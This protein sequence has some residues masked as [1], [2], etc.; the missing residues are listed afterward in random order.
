M[1]VVCFPDCFYIDH[2]T[3]QTGKSAD[4]VLEIMSV[5]HETKSIESL[6]AIICDG[7]VANT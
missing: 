3:P 1:F 7:T 4:V 6:Q 5:I 2:V